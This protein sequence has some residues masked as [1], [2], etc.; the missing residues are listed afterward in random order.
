MLVSNLDVSSSSER[1]PPH[2]QAGNDS[3]EVQSICDEEEQQGFLETEVEP[4]EE[5]VSIAERAT[6]AS[7]RVGECL[8]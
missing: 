8:G 7:R 2:D 1:A 3:H 6:R 5:V 4:M